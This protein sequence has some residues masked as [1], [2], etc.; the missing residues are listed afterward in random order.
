MHYKKIYKKIHQIEKEYKVLVRDLYKQPLLKSK[1]DH[2][3]KEDKEEFKV[4]WKRYIN[5]FD[6]M[7]KLLKAS[8]YR[9]FFFIINYNKL[10]LN[11]YLVHFYFNAI[12]DLLKSFW[13][14]E[15]FIRVFLDENFL[16]DYW[17][18]AKYIYLPKYINIINTPKIFITPFKNLIDKDIYKLIWNIKDFEINNTINADYNNLFFWIKY[19]VDKLI[20][21]ISKKVGY[22]ISHTKFTTRKHWLIS[23]KNL[24]KYLEIAKP[25]DI[26]L[27]RWNWNASNLSIPWFWKHMAMYIW[28]WEYLKKH[29][30]WEYVEILKDNSNYIIEATWKWIEIVEIFEFASHIDY[31]WA[32]RTNFSKDKIKRAI[33][34][35]IS[36]IWKWYDFIFN[37]YSDK[38]L[39][40]TALILKSYA[41]E[42]DKDEWIE[43]EL[44]KIWI[45]LTYPPNSFIK[46]LNE[47]Q[48]KKSK[49]VEGIFFIDS[50]EKTWEN[51][52]STVEELLKTWSRPKLSMFLK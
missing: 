26:L 1:R 34:N 9:S 51:F 20:F 3:L 25:G 44:E 15:V 23:N 43:I 21:L 7:K 24:S 11:K 48:E 6:K 17:V 32:S 13:K 30:K 50:F 47:E 45:N 27:T 42:N 16:K 2:Y 31:L 10:V 19:R 8:R 36:N 18:Y 41:K 38:K 35:A 33:K 28:S 49:E 37:Y 5:F 12:L 52:V 4:F 22:I 14:H 40:C 46:K 39:V 29:F